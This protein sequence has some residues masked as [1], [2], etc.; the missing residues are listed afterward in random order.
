MTHAIRAIQPQP[1]P[2]QIEQLKTSW[3]DLLRLPLATQDQRNE[4]AMTVQALSVPCAAPKLMHRVLALL[5]PYY[6]TDI[7]QSVREIE[8]ED[9]L[10]ALGEFP[11]WAVVA[12]ARWWKGDA[13]PDRRKRPMEGDIAARAKMEM[14]IVKVG[15]WAVKRF[16]DGIRPP[17]PAPP[18]A[19][20][21][22]EEMDHRR[23]FAE[24]VIAG[25]FPSNRKGAAE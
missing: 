9:W 24:S 19:A 16:D 8:A 1:A 10:V 23:K 20:P 12:A 5:A 7:P 17:P 18:R 11:E 25:K 15:E 3:P 6:S 14:G 4:I 13:N 2:A 21:T 22:A